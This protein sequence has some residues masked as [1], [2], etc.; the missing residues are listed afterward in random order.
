MAELSLRPARM[1]DVRPMLELVNGL[2]AD[3]VMLPRSPAS[4][5]ENIRD[6]VVAEVDGVFAGCG[7]LAVI[8][9]DIAEVRSI[10]VAPEHRKLGLGRALAERLLDEARRL[11]VARVMAFTYV[12]GFFEKLGFHVVEHASLPHKVFND[13]LN[14]PKF[15]K[16]DEVAVL[17]VLREG[18]TTPT[19]GPMSLPTPGSP[20][21]IIGQ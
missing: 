6:F 17:K 15:H 7:A 11:D 21:P 2:A 12:T 13:C 5:V 19:L 18:G 8:W 16:C 14:C 20:L 4:I 3:G 10:A 1:T 9:T